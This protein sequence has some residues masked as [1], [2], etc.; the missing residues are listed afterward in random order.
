MAKHP[1]WHRTGDD[2]PYLSPNWSRLVLDLEFIVFQIPSLDH[3]NVSRPD[4]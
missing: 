3:G 4:I 2:P 1:T